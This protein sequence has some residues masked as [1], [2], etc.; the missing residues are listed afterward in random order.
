[1]NFL[2]TLQV[3][4]IK[5]WAQT[6]GKE[7]LNSEYWRDLPKH[8]E[9]LELLLAWGCDTIGHCKCCSPPTEHGKIFE[10]LYD[11]YDPALVDAEIWQIIKTELS[12]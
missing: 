2:N 5:K 3:E 11:A 6:Q 9:K 10:G 1:M 8:A 12:L 4:S 7:H